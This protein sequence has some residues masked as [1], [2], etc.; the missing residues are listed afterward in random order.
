MNRRT[1]LALFNVRP[2][3]TATA[4]ARG[5]RKLPPDVVYEAAQVIRSRI[6]AALAAS[7]LDIPPSGPHR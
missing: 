2:H 6:D 1:L 7:R 3:P 4:G 5:A